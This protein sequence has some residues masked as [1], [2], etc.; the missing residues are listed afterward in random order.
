MGVVVSTATLMF[1][2][3]LG[4]HLM[5]WDSGVPGR[6]GWNHAGVPESGLTDSKQLLRFSAGRQ[7]VKPFANL[8]EGCIVTPFGFLPGIGG[9]PWGL[10]PV[11]PSPRGGDALF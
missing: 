10:G 2:I 9:R 3:I 8:T 6:S 7:P 5:S 1:W 11:I 4:K